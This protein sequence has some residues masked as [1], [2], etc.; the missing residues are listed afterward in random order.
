MVATESCRN[1]TLSFSLSLSPPELHPVVW[2]EREEEHIH[3]S[4]SLFP[5]T[6]PVNRNRLVNVIDTDPEGRGEKD[7]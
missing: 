3:H 5:P 6:S 2:A 4:A 1:E 7:I